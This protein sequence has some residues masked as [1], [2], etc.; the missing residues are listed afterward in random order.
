MTD[1]HQL[2]E[3]LQRIQQVMK[4]RQHER[5]VNSRVVDEVEELLARGLNLCGDAPL[6]GELQ[7]VRLEYDNGRVE[8][9][10]GD[11]AR[12]WWD[13]LDALA[14]FARLHRHPYDPQDYTWDVTT[15]GADPVTRQLEE[16]KRQL[17]Q[18][19]NALQEPARKLPPLETNAA[20][21]LIQ[22]TA[23]VPTRIN[24]T[25]H[26]A[27]RQILG[28]MTIDE[29]VEADAGQI[30]RLFQRSPQASVGMKTITGVK[31]LIRSEQQK[32]A[33]TVGRRP[34]IEF[35]TKHW[36]RLPEPIQ[37]MRQFQLEEALIGRDLLE[38]ASG[39][40]QTVAQF[41]PS[42]ITPEIIHELQKRI[43]DILNQYKG[44][45]HHG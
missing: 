2:Q 13:D 3:I 6:G 5:L 19:L 39:N 4:T 32:R 10:T 28:T 25:P 34:A 16:V 43:L 8:Q 41:F 9:L 35:F 17:T 42:W 30:H 31:A 33:E 1:I 7:R 12:E 15:G 27:L 29:F 24:T 45:Q 37:N 23:V 11:D 44:E 38:V 20:E 40:P 36:T 21:F 14:G 26:A 22:H 18:T